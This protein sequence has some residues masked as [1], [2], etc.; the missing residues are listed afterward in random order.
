VARD[1]VPLSDGAGR[2]E[3]VGAGVEHFE[4]GDRVAATFRQ[5][6]SAMDALGSPRDG[7]LTEYAVFAE[8]GLVRVPENLSYEQAATLPC[9]GVT[10]WN[11]I[12]GGRQI[13]PGETVA[14]L[15]TGGVSL[16]ALQIAKA[17]GARV[18]ITSS[19]DEKLEK[20]KAL[21]AD[22]T[23]NYESHPDWEHAVADLT[24]GKGA[25]QV[26]D[27]GGPGTLPH[28][29]QAV[30]PGGEIAM[31]GVITRPEGDLSPLPLMPKEAT[32]RGIFVGGKALFEELNR[33][34][35]VN[36]IEPVID[37]VFEFDAAREAYEYLRSAKHMG[38]VVIRIAPA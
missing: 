23:I 1:T 12:I 5:G 10:A 17:A 3:A 2:V 30:G 6:D 22:E 13:K 32:L 20:A 8:H 35:E 9:A 36:S 38:K 27:L 28:S 24:G 34:V 21:G 18:I 26:V 19:S 4:V 15:G 16:F 14:T 7:V 33:A 29:Y 31:I 25:E 37:S 11:A